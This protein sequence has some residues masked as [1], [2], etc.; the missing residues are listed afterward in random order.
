MV[1]VSL[2]RHESYYEELR[3]IYHGVS[4][5]VVRLSNLLVGESSSESRFANH[6]M[7]F[8]HIWSRLGQRFCACLG[9]V[10]SAESAKS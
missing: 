3:Q 6:K 7:I 8:R 10:V 1:L 4:H 5:V 9:F 2:G